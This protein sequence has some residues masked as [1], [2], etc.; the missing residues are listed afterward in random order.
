MIDA[1]VELWKV[2]L[3]EAKAAYTTKMEADIAR[4]IETRKTWFG[5][6]TRTR[7]QAV[8]YLSNTWYWMDREQRVINRAANNLERLEEIRVLASEKNFKN[9]TLPESDLRLVGGHSE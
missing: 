5:T 8:S 6:R 9:I 3:E 7:E 4:V 2:K 1:A